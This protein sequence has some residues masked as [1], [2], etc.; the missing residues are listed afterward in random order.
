MA[1]LSAA[2]A[3]GEVADRIRSRRGGALRPLDEVLLH[4]P[5]VADG[6]NSLLGAI[7]ARMSL[8]SALRELVILRV[9]V[10]NSADYEWHA[11]LAAA[12]QA[13]L[14]PAQLAALRRDDAAE[15]IELT[16]LQRQCVAFTDAVTRDVAVPDAVFDAVHERLGER[17]TMEL[18]VTAAAYNMV[19]RFLVALQVSDADSPAEAEAELRGG[20]A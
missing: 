18:A 17:Q 6:W 8:P 15:A 14:R 4:S 9:A 5:P 16:D 3:D 20:P 10:L 11:H 2:A 19:S 7:R 13:G 12:D 1:R